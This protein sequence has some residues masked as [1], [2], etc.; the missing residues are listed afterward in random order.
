MR[1]TLFLTATAI[2]F[3]LVASCGEEQA[4]DAFLLVPGERAGLFFLNREYEPVE[5]LY[6]G[7]GF[8]EEEDDWSGIN[9]LCDSEVVL[10][11]DRMT[12]EGEDTQIDNTVGKRIAIYSSDFLTAQKIGVGA[13]LQDL[14]DNYPTYRI[15]V[16]YIP[17]YDYAPLEYDEYDDVESLF[18]YIRQNGFEKI[19]PYGTTFSCLDADGEESGIRFYFWIAYDINEKVLTKETKITTIVIH[20]EKWER[21]YTAWF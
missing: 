18:E 8:S 12:E 2:M 20:A 3:M 6:K 7:Y 9:I 15:E 1:K 16:D 13:S 19:D 4:N 10:S 14:L 21:E 5:T 17:E 11:F